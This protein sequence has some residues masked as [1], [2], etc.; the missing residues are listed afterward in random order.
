MATSI[1]EALSGGSLSVS[2]KPV[3]MEQLPDATI[4]VAGGSQALDISTPGG[5]KRKRTDPSIQTSSTSQLAIQDLFGDLLDQVDFANPVS[6]DAFRASAANRINEFGPDTFDTIASSA[7]TVTSDLDTLAGSL[8]VTPAAQPAQQQFEQ[9]FGPSRVT[10]G[11]DAD[12]QTSDIGL[13]TTTST[14]LQDISNLTNPGLAASLFGGALGSFGRGADLTDFASGLAT[15][16]LGQADVVGAF[17][18][19]N[20]AQGI[21]NALDRGITNPTDA[22]AAI[23]AGLAVKD[24]ALEVQ[25]LI[26][27]GMSLNSLFERA[28]KNVE[29]YIQGFVTAVTNPAQTMEAYGRQAEFGT[30]T[31]DL[32]SFDFPGGKM[33]F[34]FDAKTGAVAVPGFLSTMVGLSPLGRAFN[35][36]Q[37][38]LSAVGYTDAMADRN[39]SAINAYSV[40]GV[41]SGKMSVHSSSVDALTG[42]NPETGAASAVGAFSA[43]DMSQSGFGT[44]GFDLGALADAIGTGTINDLGFTDFQDAAISGHL[45]HGPLGP[46]EEEDLVQ[47]MVADFSDAGLDTAQGI[48][49]K[50]EQA[51]QAAAAF[52]ANLESF[53][54]LDIAS[55]GVGYGS[56]SRAGALSASQAAAIKEKAE[57]DPYGVIAARTFTPTPPGIG[58]SMLDKRERVQK[59]EVEKYEAR[60]SQAAEN[61]AASYN[62]PNPRGASIDIATKTMSRTGR[63]TF[64]IARDKKVAE[65]VVAELNISGDLDFGYDDAPPSIGPSGVSAPGYEAQGLQ[66]GRTGQVGVTPEFIEALEGISVEE[67][68]PNYDPGIDEPGSPNEADGGGGGGGAKVICTAL[69]DMS[70]LDEEL[71]QHDGAYGRT[72]P[73]ET[74]QGYWAWG[75]PTAKFIRKN[76][77]AAK[78]IRPVVTEVAKEMAH[79]VGY[80]RGSKLGAALLYLGLPMCR[81]INRI[82]NNGNNTRS[83]YS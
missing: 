28:A 37:R 70:L 75:V 17:G 83:V 43:L 33:N 41:G 22:I 78:A 4:D 65:E 67:E 60:V 69:K 68:D 8:R 2:A 9:V 29:E 42:I 53:T 11:D 31:P 36:A 20:A 48:A 49:D 10:T 81:V 64:N 27:R 62:S 12:P 82:K 74:R 7:S 40:P 1:E 77:W 35:L 21:S 32:Y 5:Q 79:R 38:G 34:A 39:L 52:A 61:A 30:L 80:G 63:N 50:A 6:V 23:D 18:G 25:G 16:G 58:M 73:L 51:S 47:T 59:S 56:L 72:L 76:R 14:E 3:A 71:W 55:L 15:Q 19:F 26:N 13:D 66:A 45:G 44:V 46:D 54:G 24:K 57:L